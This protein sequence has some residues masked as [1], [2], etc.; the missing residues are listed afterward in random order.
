VIP[1]REM[2]F[3]DSLAEVVEDRLSDGRAQRP[4]VPAVQRL[5]DGLKRAV[6][7]DQEGHCAP[8]VARARAFKG[9]EVG[10]QVLL[11]ARNPHT[12]GRA[13]VSGHGRPL[14]CKGLSQRWS[15]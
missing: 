5:A 2:R 6:D 15:A 9:V 4:L 1:Y 7:G 8:E 10:Q 11:A 13:V 14:G 3:T 12:D